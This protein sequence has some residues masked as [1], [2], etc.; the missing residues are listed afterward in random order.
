[1]RTPRC[2]RW[3]AGGPAVHLPAG[4]GRGYGAAALPRGVRP[5][6]DVRGDGASHRGAARHAGGGVR[7]AHHTGVNLRLPPDMTHLITTTTRRRGP[8]GPG[9][10]NKGTRPRARQLGGPADY[11]Y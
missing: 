7:G 9:W 4:G 5:G 11:Y 10:S 6:A 1:M 2:T 3:C 8:P